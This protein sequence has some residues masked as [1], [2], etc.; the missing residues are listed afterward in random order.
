M[1]DLAGPAPTNG[2]AILE[3][4]HVSLPGPWLGS[5]NPCQLMGVPPVHPHGPPS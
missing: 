4:S 2:S 1:R 5:R 3:C